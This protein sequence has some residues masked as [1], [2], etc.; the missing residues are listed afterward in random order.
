MDLGEWATRVLREVSEQGDR[1]ER[2][3]LVSTDGNSWES[4]YAPFP[5][6]EVWKDEAEAVVAQLA[7]DW[8][9]QDIQLLF[10]AENRAGTILSQCTKRTRGRAKGASGNVFGGPGKA[11]AESMDAQARTMDR[12]L[13]TANTQLELMQTAL[14][15]QTA[16]NQ[17]LIAQN[18]NLLLQLQHEALARQDARPT[19]SPEIVNQ[20]MEMLPGLIQAIMQRDVPKTPQ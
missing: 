9:P 16:Q 4:W 20:A 10:V 18:Q 13:G 3:R 5:A 1:C 6:P 2:I 19:V 12:I 7:E 14:A 11:L 17:A 15:G 8:P